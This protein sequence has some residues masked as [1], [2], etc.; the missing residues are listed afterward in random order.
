MSHALQLLQVNR[1]EVELHDR[2]AN[3]A[4]RGVAALGP[5]KAQQIAEQ[6]SGHDIGHHIDGP[7][8]GDPPDFRHQVAAAPR[9]HC[10]GAHRNR[11]AS[12]PRPTTA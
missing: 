2:P 12:F 8:G 4:G 6:R 9:H 3:S 10:L 7:A 5:E 1:P 11:L